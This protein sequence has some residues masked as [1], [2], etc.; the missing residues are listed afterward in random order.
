[1]TDHRGLYQKFTVTRTDGRSNPGQ[2]HEH[3][4]YFVLDLTH[5]PYAVA[6][7]H[8]YVMAC[9]KD[10]PRLAYDLAILLVKTQEERKR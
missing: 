7:L 5:D 3:C 10:R 8:A 2:K 1:M 9:R 6:A 4:Q